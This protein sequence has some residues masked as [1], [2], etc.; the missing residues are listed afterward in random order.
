ME[1]PISE[2]L[3]PNDIKNRE[4]K[5]S[6]RG[7]CPRDVVEFLDEVATVWE[8][9]QTHEKKLLKEIESLN[10]QLRGW[11][12]RRTEMDDLRNKALKEAES[13]RI[14]ASEEGVRLIREVEARASG[15][16]LKT[17]EWLARVIADLEETQRQKNNFVS[18]FKSALDSH[19]ELIKPDLSSG[20]ALGNQL[21]D[22]LQKRDK[23][24]SDLERH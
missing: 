11:E 1:T 2:K 14:Q 4:F 23:E 5:K 12:N 22:F 16:R 13:I 24:G 21:K 9:V 7:Y 19:Y 6:M 15:V 10:E 20:E 8:S 17:E 18:A 3:T